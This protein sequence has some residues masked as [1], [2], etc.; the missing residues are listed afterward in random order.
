M[1][2]IVVLYMTVIRDFFFILAFLGR[3]QLARADDDNVHTQ[4]KRD[5]SVHERKWKL[6]IQLCEHFFFFVTFWS[7]FLQKKKFLLKTFS[8]EN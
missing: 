5:D 1:L 7:F 6:R 8:I 4:N 3:L 2:C